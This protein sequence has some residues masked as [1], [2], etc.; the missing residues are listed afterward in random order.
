MAEIS[1]IGIFCEDIREEKSGQITLIGILPDAINVPSMPGMLAKLCLYVRIHISPADT[2]LERVAAR[3]IMPDGN[4]LVASEID[5]ERIASGRDKAVASGNPILGFIL[6]FS[7]TPLPIAS[8][9]RLLAEVT[10]GQQTSICGALT[11]NLTPS[12]T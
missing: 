9:G 12:P 3:I 10:I 4:E 5:K 1:A 2:D 11:V 6:R 8:P 7:A